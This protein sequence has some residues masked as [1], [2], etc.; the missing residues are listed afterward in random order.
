M[1]IIPSKSFSFKKQ[2]FKSTAG[3]SEQAIYRKVAALGKGGDLSRSDRSVLM[4]MV[5]LWF[6]HRGR[7]GY[8][9]PS[10][11]KIEKECGLSERAVRRAF[12]KLRSLGIFTLLGGGVGRGNTAKYGVDLNRMREVIWPDF[13][14]KIRGFWCKISDLL[15]GAT[16]ASSLYIDNKPSCSLPGMRLNRCATIGTISALGRRI[17]AA[18][19]PWFKSQPKQTHWTGKFSGL[20]CPSTGEILGSVRAL[21]M[22]A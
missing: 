9:E 17:R 21:R 4:K 2:D 20:V 14:I 11:A 1:R 16:E 12:S 13:A 3:Y 7:I 6:Y 5:N 15:K 18:L 8:V 22:D 10:H 19:V